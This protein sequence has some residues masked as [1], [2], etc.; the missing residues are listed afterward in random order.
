MNLSERLDYFIGGDPYFMASPVEAD[1]I[2]MLRF[3]SLLTISL[4]LPFLR[5]TFGKW[6][7]GKT[8]CQF[9]QPLN[10]ARFVGTLLISSHR[11][12]ILLAH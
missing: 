11:H 2:P 12:R 8:L 9:D 7:Q 1:Y 5:P 3:D 4:N 10:L 6:K